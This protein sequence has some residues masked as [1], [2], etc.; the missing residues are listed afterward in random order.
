M[1][2]D[3][4]DEAFTTQRSSVDINN[5][6]AV[7]RTIVRKFYRSIRSRT[8]STYP[9]HGRARCQAVRS[10]G[11]GRCSRSGA[12]ES[13]QDVLRGRT[14]RVHRPARSETAEHCSN[15][16]RIRPPTATHGSGSADADSLEAGLV[17]QDAI[18]RQ[19]RGWK[20]CGN[21]L[22]DDLERAKQG[23]GVPL[24]TSADHA[25]NFAASPPAAARMPYGRFDGAVFVA[26]RKPSYHAFKL[27]RAI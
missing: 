21:W 1:A 20:L 9:L 10:Q 15:T 18:A 19:A 8:H 6:W 23:T 5:Y 22:L 13:L 4:K 16:C 2:A 26:G 11:R 25:P 17:D 3:L 27:A 12:S 14:S 7:E 24:A